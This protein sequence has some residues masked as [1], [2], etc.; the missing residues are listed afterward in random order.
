MIQVAP[1]NGTLRAMCRSLFDEDG[2]PNNTN[3]EEQRPVAPGNAMVFVIGE[4]LRKKSFH[5]ESCGMVKKWQKQLPTNVSSAPQP[6]S[7]KP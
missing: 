4:M 5:T 1:T 3:N 7:P 6:S 2:A